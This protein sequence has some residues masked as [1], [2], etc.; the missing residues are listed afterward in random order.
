MAAFAA[1]PFAA[2]V[3]ARRARGALG[4]VA[5]D[6][7]LQ[8]DD[9]EEDVALAAQFVGH[10]RRLGRDGRHHCH[11]HALALD[12][13]DQRAEVASPENSTKSSTVLADLHRVDRK[14]DVHVALDLAAAGWSTNSLV[15]LVTTVQPL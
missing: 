2:V 15:A 13:L 7:G 11:A 4:G 14:L 8:L 6:L 10:H 3:A 5:A 9:V 12:R 1:A